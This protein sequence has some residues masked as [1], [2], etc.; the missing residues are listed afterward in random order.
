[1][2]VSWRTVDHRERVADHLGFED[3][4]SGNAGRRTG[5]AWRLGS[6]AGRAGHEGSV[7]MVGA[8]EG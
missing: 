4:Q 2:G 5:V 8:R 7:G 1:M 3:G 6:V